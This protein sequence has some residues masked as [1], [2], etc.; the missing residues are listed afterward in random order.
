MRVL[1]HT[2]P[3]R[4]HT[5]PLVPLAWALRAAGHDVL[6]ASAGEGTVVTEAGLSMVDIAPGFDIRPMFMPLF[7]RHQGLYESRATSPAEADTIAEIF[8]T[9]NG[10][11]APGL[12][13]AARRWR[14]DLIVHDSSATAGAMCAALL[15]IPAVQHDVY[16]ESSRGQR[17]R[18]AS[19]MTDTF[20]RFGVAGL[21]ADPVALHITPPSVEPE[22]QYG[23][24]MRNLCYS[25]GAE[26][27]DWLT[28]PKQRPTVA[29]TMGLTWGEIGP[30]ER[31]ITAA[32]E[33]DADF[34][35]AISGYDLSKY[36]TLPSNVRAAGW[37][38][39]S[40]LLP[41]CTAVIHHGGGGTSLTSLALGLPQL[42]FAGGIGHYAAAAA[43]GR[44]GAG[45]FADADAI[46][47]E[48]F[49]R[50][51]KDDAIR[52][53]AAE[54]RAEVAA[55]PSPGEIA[56]RLGAMVAGGGDGRG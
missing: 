20:E 15:G 5:L 11:L 43:I 3:I 2:A 41:R 39:L 47:P 40:D 36:G 24:A 29:V 38:P 32:G 21:P 10:E 12:V 7:R 44:R 19:Y 16:L 54:V 48:L 1:F 18:I 45:I 33:V 25:G 53:A 51:L 23:W 13:E 56:A 28:A 31:I 6:F 49:R 30:V 34:V 22:G 8:G 37:I 9:A 50:W 35:L 14:P 52:R 42:V 26:L 55:L 46:E 17:E 4:A 27:P